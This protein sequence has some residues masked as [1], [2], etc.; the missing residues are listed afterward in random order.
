MLLLLFILGPFAR[1][2]L[3]TLQ[4][5]SPKQTTPGV[6]KGI[7]SKIFTRLPTLLAGIGGFSLFCFWIIRL[8]INGNNKQ[9]K[10]CN[11]FT[12]NV[13]QFNG[14]Q[15]LLKFTSFVLCHTLWVVVSNVYLVCTCPERFY[16]AYM[17]VWYAFDEIKSRFVHVSAIE[18]GKGREPF[19]VP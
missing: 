17:R 18:V 2:K 15:M 4:A 8:P 13:V 1:I 5:S 7:E 12:L 3:L 11:H 16:T 14:V 6:K 19:L 9:T 10:E